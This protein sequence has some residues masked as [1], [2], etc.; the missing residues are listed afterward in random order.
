MPTSAGETVRVLLVEDHGLVADALMAAFRSVTTV[1]LVGRA[2]S[3][4]TGVAAAARLVPDVVLLDRRLP[5]GDGIEAIPRFREASP[6]GRVLVLTGEAGSQAAAR[7]LEL[8]GCGLMLKSGRFD[9]LVTAIRTVAEGTF[10]LDTELLSGAFAT[11][12]GQTAGGSPALTPREREVLVLLGRGA[13]T[14]AIAEDLL[15]SQNT[16]RN[17]VQRILGKLGAH[18]KLEAVAR[19]RE[20]GLL[21]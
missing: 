5:D 17:H 7:L 12:A 21:D 18:S 19:A 9:E 2:S 10:V 16:V 8:G 14:E 15:L 3:I 1:E 11:L 20:N 6:G 13:G 4:E